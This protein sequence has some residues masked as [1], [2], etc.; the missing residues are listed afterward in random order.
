MGQITKKLKKRL[1]QYKKPQKINAISALLDGKRIADMAAETIATVK[2]L[3]ENE[4][5][6]VHALYVNTQ[7][8]LSFFAEQISE[9][10][11]LKPFCV[12]AAKAED[13]YVPS[14][15]PMSPLTS[16]YY[17]YWL[18]SDMV[19]GPDKE[20]IIDCFLGVATDI[21]IDEMHQKAVLALKNSRMGIYEHM[22]AENQKI[23][24]KELVSEKTY[25][26][27]SSSGYKGSKGELWYVRLLPDPSNMV[28]YGIIVT[29]PYVVYG[30]SS[31]DWEAFFARN[32]IIASQLG[33]QNRLHAFMKFGPELHYWH[34]YV[35]LA[36]SRHTADAV[37]VTGI[38]DLK[39]TLPH[40]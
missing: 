30:Q 10:P 6:P 15:P 37:Y 23:I 2:D 21:K 9:F 19:F 28:D 8:I 12:K 33:Y 22:G 1:E 24:L 26:C 5:D 25:H 36:Y 38:P 17:G 32:N 7:N 16:S 11:E 3:V 31:K 34:E 4:Y 20:T 13:I 29:T 14:G 39:E 35:F 18:L 27:V 40:A